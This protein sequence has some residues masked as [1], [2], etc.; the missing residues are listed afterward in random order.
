VSS[1]GAVQMDCC[2]FRGD[3]DRISKSLLDAL[4]RV[5]HCKCCVTEGHI[6]IFDE[7]Y[8]KR[9]M[10]NILLCK[11][12]DVNPDDLD[13][14][15]HRFI[16]RTYCYNPERYVP[17]QVEELEYVDHG[18]SGINLGEC[19]G[20]CFADWQ[21][22]TGLRCSYRKAGEYLDGRSFVPGCSGVGLPDVNYW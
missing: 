9:D 4:V 17:E 16:S 5:S 20:H 10:P 15:V 11:Q 21:C 2:A 3:S 12:V 8:C 6:L 22:Q 13:L 18:W 7:K 1:T 14:F 19:Q